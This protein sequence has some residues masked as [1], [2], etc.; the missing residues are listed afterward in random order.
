MP[1]HSTC[2]QWYLLLEVEPHD[3]V[4][5]GVSAVDDLVAT[6]LDE[7]AQRL[8]ARKTLPN[9]LSL[10]RRSLFH[11]HFV[12]VLSQAGLALLVH[13]QQELYHQFYQ[14]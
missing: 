7:G 10:Q 8:V 2:L 1:F 14:L 4:E 13:H 9:Q 12:V 5:T 6:V 3:E 11:R